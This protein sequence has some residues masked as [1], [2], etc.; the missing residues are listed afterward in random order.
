MQARKT[1]LRVAVDLG[2][3]LVER[4]KATRQQG[5]E[6]SILLAAATLRMASLHIHL[7]E[8]EAG[9]IRVGTKLALEV[10]VVRI[11]RLAEVVDR[12]SMELILVRLAVVLREV[13]MHRTVVAEPERPSV[14]APPR[15]YR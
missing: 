13:G 4:R 2:S 14:V 7:E 8:L 11:D 10:V 5:E 3:R 15:S 12:E 6:D 1:R 9:R